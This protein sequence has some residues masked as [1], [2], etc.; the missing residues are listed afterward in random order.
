M[1]LHESLHNFAQVGI[2]FFEATFSTKVGNK[3]ALENSLNYERVDVDFSNLAPWIFLKHGIINYI[4]TI[5]IMG[6]ILGLKL[7]LEEY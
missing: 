1:N 5:P 7:V 2:G 4:T 3:H 6:S